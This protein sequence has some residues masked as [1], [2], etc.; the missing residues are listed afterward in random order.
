M[1]ATQILAKQIANHFFNKDLADEIARFILQDSDMQESLWKE[2]EDHI[3]VE[4]KQSTVTINFMSRPPSLA[5]TFGE[6]GA[7]ILRLPLDLSEWVDEDAPDDVVDD[8]SPEDIAEQIGGIQL[9]IDIL[10]RRKANFERAL[11]ILKE[12][13]GSPS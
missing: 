10:Q 8:F 4:L 13:Q 3:L 6:Q 5:F 11:L 1:K 7:D 12:E 2:I 9:T